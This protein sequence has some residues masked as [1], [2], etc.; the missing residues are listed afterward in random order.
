MEQKQQVSS[1][2]TGPEAVPLGLREQDVDQRHLHQLGLTHWLLPLD[3][4][5]QIAMTARAGFK[6]RGWRGKAGEETAL[7]TVEK[8]F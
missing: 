4:Q 8:D 3:A 5:W 2:R 7:L 6:D 1:K